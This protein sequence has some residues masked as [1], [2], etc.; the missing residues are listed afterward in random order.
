M[1]TALAHTLR[2]F[3]FSIPVNFNIKFIKILCVKIYTQFFK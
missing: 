3:D 1:L 2:E